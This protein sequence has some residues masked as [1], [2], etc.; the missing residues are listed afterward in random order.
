MTV[1]M[2]SCFLVGFLSRCKCKTCAGPPFQELYRVFVK[3]VLCL[4]LN[5]VRASDGLKKHKKDDSKMQNCPS[6]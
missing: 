5:T 4:E 2:H 1:S 6:A 3:V